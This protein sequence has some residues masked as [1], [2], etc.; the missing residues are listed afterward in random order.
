MSNISLF[1][2]I[3]VIWSE[4]YVLDQHAKYMLG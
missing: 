4:E 2:I 1:N 3:I